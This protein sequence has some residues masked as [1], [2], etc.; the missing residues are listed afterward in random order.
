[1]TD[2]L[3]HILAKYE[4][5]AGSLIIDPSMK[6]VQLVAVGG[7]K[8]DYYWITY[9]GREVS[10]TSC[11][12]GIIRL[13]DTILDHEYDSLIRRCKLNYFTYMSDSFPVA[14]NDKEDELLTPLNWELT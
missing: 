11:V 7:D 8:Y 10:W 12:G 3:T 1:M 13:K 2:N 5:N 14:F 4:A 6:V 9:N